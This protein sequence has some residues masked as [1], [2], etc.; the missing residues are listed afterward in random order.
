M[1]QFDQ[2]IWNTSQRRLMVNTLKP[3]NTLA[4]H[5]SPGLVL[6]APLYWVWEDIR[7][8]IL[9]QATAYAASGLP[10]YFYAR[11]RWGTLPS[12]GVL[13]AYY[14]SATLHRLAL[15]EFRRISL[16]VPGIAL[17]WYG[18]RE[19]R[20]GPLLAGLGW[21][22]LF[23]EDVTALVMAFGL[24]LA[25][26]PGQRKKLGGALVVASIAWLGLALGVAIPHF[27]GTSPSESA[28]GQLGYYQ[29]L[30]HE[31]TMAAITSL[32]RQPWQILRNVVQ[33]DR[34]RALLREL[35]SLAMLPLLAPEWLALALP[36]LMLMFATDV[37]AVYSLQAWYMAAIWPVFYGAALVGIERLG[38]WKGPRL[39]DWG[40]V[41]LILAVLGGYLAHS[42]APG[43]GRYEPSRY[44]VDPRHLAGAQALA[45]IADDAAVS[46]QTGTATHLSHR[47]LIWEYPR[48]LE[49]ADNVALDLYG[50][51]YPLGK[52]EYVVT[53]RELLMDTSWY[54]AADGGGFIVLERTSERGPMR[55]TNQSLSGMATLVGWDICGGSPERVLQPLHGDTLRIEPGDRLRI[56]LYWRADTSIAADY[57]VFVHL[58]TDQDR[59]VAQHDAPPGWLDLWPDTWVP[60]GA[61]QCTRAWTPDQTVRDVHYIDVPIDA[62]AVTGKI[63]VGW[64]DS[65]TMERLGVD[66]GTDHITLVEFEISEGGISR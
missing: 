21:A 57:S 1:G 15:G 3:P 58:L 35:A 20:N 38:Q 30:D 36:S 5:F 65:V 27:Q 31:N 64:Y 60:P 49:K 46:A 16:A 44:R 42:P 37:S 41:A 4:W 12:V 9:L 2:A 54:I 52:E 53:T 33:I 66:G 8:L 39:R 7:V 43:G 55:A 45:V 56:D 25:L 22:I 48:G 24:Y 17:A 61:P 29:A 6:I 11:K 28:Y 59:L 26:A 63:V 19:E 34:L 40:M 62:E 47:E 50:H 32:L 18:L 10:F 13:A 23:K 51:T 14:G